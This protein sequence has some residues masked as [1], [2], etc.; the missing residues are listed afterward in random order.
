MHCG[1]LF[2][3]NLRQELPSREFPSEKNSLTPVVKLYRLRRV[4]R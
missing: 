1:I 3:L 2:V 4:F